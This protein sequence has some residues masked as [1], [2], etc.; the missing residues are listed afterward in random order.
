MSTRSGLN[1][2]IPRRIASAVR[3]ELT[4]MLGCG[5]VVLLCAPPAFALPIASGRSTSQADNSHAL[6]SIPPGISAWSF[7]HP[8]SN[9]HEEATPGAPALTSAPSSL[10]A[11]T[12]FVAVSNDEASDWNCDNGDGEDLRSTSQFISW[13]QVRAGM[14]R[15]LRHSSGTSRAERA[16]S[17]VSLAGVDCRKPPPSNLRSVLGNDAYCDSGKLFPSRLFRPPRFAATVS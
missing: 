17:E 7:L 5:V 6:E 13:I 11:S 2:A 12:L 1:L 3:R 9:E 16:E 8:G 14:Q 15:T 10:L 4:F